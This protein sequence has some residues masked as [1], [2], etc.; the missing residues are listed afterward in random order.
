MDGLAGK[1]PAHHIDLMLVLRR[2][3]TSDTSGE[4]S[5]EEFDVLNDGAL[6]GRI[7]RSPAASSDRP[8]R[9]TINKQ[10]CGGARNRGDGESL[11]VAMAGLS[12]RWE[13]SGQSGG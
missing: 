9:W 1:T 10:L 5:D 4:W 7:L 2:K 3:M 6:V 13:A 8:W 12:L 11:E